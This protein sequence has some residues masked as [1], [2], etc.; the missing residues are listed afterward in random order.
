MPTFRRLAC[1]PLTLCLAAQAP[2]P[3]LDVLPD[4]ALG[5][6]LFRDPLLSQVKLQGL[7]QRLKQKK[8]D[9]LTEAQK[10]F[11]LPRLPPGRQGMALVF[12]EDGG[13]N[14]KGPLQ[15]A[16]LS[17]TDAKGYLETLKATSKD[18]KLWSYETQGK[19]FAAAMKDGWV[20]L[21][22][23][24]AKAQVRRLSETVSPLRKEAGSLGAWM[25][26]GEA[27]G[28]VTPKGLWTF[29]HD[30]KKALGGPSQAEQAD[31]FMAK[32]ERELDLVALQGRLDA[33]GN[34]VLSV[35]ARLNPRGEWMAMGRDLPLADGLGIASL[36]RLDYQAAAGGNLPSEWLQAIGSLG[37]ESLY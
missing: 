4:K 26:G 30:A 12:L 17:P 31:P 11:G 18:G 10:T 7:M 36:P 19:H 6:I 16:Y 2:R 27:F 21:G 29:F 32:A 28:M 34:L 1:L 9:P 13:A 22:P 20:I 35:R 24:G 8:D 25:E 33:D 37:T 3:A 15:L 14:A 5:F 23:E